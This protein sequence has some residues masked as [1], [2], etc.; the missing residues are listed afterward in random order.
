[1]GVNSAE[2]VVH[3]HDI[4]I[5][6]DGSRDIEPLFLASGDGDAPFTNFRQIAIRQHVKIGL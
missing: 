5:K 2:R 1:M 6:V 3:E 4:R